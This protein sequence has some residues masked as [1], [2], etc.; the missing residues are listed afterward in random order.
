[1]NSRK[2]V[3]L[4]VDSYD[5]YFYRWIAYHLYHSTA[6]HLLAKLYTDFG[7]LGQKMRALDANDIMADINK[8]KIEIAN[9]DNRK[10]SLTKFNN[11]L[12]KTE[13]KITM[14]EDCCLLQY[15]LFSSENFIRE[16]ALKQIE[17]FPQRLWF[18]ERFVIENIV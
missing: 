1:M 6:K 16:L 14:Y 8:Y 17:K 15:A 9:V 18:T 13:E 12:G 2:D 7:F 11:F 4:D 10:F 3:D 5:D